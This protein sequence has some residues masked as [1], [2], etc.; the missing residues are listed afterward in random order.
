MHGMN[1]EW[2]TQF[3]IGLIIGMIILVVVILVMFRTLNKRRNP[4]KRYRRW[5]VDILKK[6]NRPG[7]LDKDEIDKRNGNLP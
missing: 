1:N 5:P 6:Q 3:G 7:K 4:H 2:I